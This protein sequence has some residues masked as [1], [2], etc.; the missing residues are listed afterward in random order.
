MAAL[1]FVVKAIDEATDVLKGIG[2]E[3]EGLG[4]RLSRVGD[5][6]GSGFD[7]LGKATIAA[8]RRVRGACGGRHQARG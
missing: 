5:I 7:A 3:A 1:S 2:D 6:A 8:G 4:G